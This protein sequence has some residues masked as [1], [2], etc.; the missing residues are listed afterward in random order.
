[1]IQ[2]ILR[3]YYISFL[4]LSCHYT[5]LF[6]IQES[7]RILNIQLHVNR[8]ILLY[9][10]CTSI[11]NFNKF[12][13][14][15]F[16]KWREIMK[17]RKRKKKEHLHLHRLAMR[18]V[19][20]RRVG[21]SESIVPG[22]DVS[23]PFHRPPRPATSNWRTLPG[24]NRGRRGECDLIPLESRRGDGATGDFISRNG[25][26]DLQRRV[27]DGRFWKQKG[28]MGH[29][30]QLCKNHYRQLEPRFVDSASCENPNTLPSIAWIPFFP[31]PYALR[32]LL[33]SIF[34][35]FLLYM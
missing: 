18:P 23:R 12:S 20:E 3:F 22:I 19:G 11:R 4:N 9:S 26:H 14:D 29:L 24:E 25:A 34:F 7:K 17:K 16:E 10:N 5:L 15:T 35:P 1:M 31:S 8:R 27:Q 13:A 6:G 30:Y 2:Q 33:I 21:S 28:T 32:T